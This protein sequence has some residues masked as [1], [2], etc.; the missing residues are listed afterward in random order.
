MLP[1]YFLFSVVIENGVDSVINGAKCTALPRDLGAA[2]GVL[3]D[4]GDLAIVRVGRVPRGHIVAACGVCLFG[5]CCGCRGRSAGG[6]ASS[7]CSAF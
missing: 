4:G 7:I 3:V 1:L 6:L 5:R 2:V